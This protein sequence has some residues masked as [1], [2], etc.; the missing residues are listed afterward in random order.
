MKITKIPH[1]MGFWGNTGDL[2]ADT[3]DG[4][5][6]PDDPLLTIFQNTVRYMTSNPIYQPPNPWPK[7]MTLL[8]VSDTKL[9]GAGFMSMDEFEKHQ[10]E[11]FFAKLEGEM[12]KSGQNQFKLTRVIF[13]PCL[14]MPS[15]PE[16]AAMMAAGIMSQDNFM[17]IV[18][19]LITNR[20]YIDRVPKGMN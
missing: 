20:W 2:K 10:P 6:S 9:V 7:S 3:P 16:Q 5:V 8:F 11:S 12:N 17:A 18:K 14:Q 4:L 15:S 13:S 1:E 19:Y